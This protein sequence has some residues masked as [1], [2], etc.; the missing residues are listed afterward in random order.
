P[1]PAIEAA[2]NRKNAV[3]FRGCE[4]DGN[5]PEKRDKGQKDQ[6]HTRAGALKNLFVAEWSAGR[7]AICQGEKRKKSDLAQVR[8]RAGRV[9]MVAFES[10]RHRLRCERA[11][12]S[13]SLAVFN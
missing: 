4:G 9:G 8:R 10:L 11:I 13:E 6:R 5:T 2:L 1:N 12:V 3:H 7:V